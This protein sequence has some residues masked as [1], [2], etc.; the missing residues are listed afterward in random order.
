[1]KTVELEKFEQKTTNI[2]FIQMLSIFFLLFSFALFLCKYFFLSFFSKY[3]SLKKCQYEIFIPNST[4]YA[5]TT[6][7]AV[8]DFHS[9]QFT[10]HRINFLY[11]NYWNYNPY[12]KSNIFKIRVICSNDFTPSFA[13]LSSQIKIQ[14]IPV[15]CFDS[16]HDLSCRV[17]EG[18]KSFLNDS[19]NKKIGWLF[20]ATD[21][22]FIDF[23]NLF[24]YI[25][26]LNKNY[27]SM[28]DLVVRAHANFEMKSNYYIHGGPGY[29]MSREYV[30]YHFVSNLTLNR[31]KA[32][33]KYKQDDT[34]ESIIVRKM[35]KRYRQWD[36][37]YIDGF[38]CRNCHLTNVQSGN[39]PKCPPDKRIGN[40]KKM[41]SFHM[42]GL[43][44]QQLLFLN[45]LDK[46]H[47]HNKINISLIDNVRFY[48]DDNSQ[49]LMLCRSKFVKTENYNTD[50]NKKIQISQLKNPLIDIKSLKRESDYSYLFEK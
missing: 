17:D 40:L 4:K 34:A 41:I 12:L 32:Y 45:L 46:I 36:E 11:K 49:S 26:M 9:S 30:K 14:L 42:F 38:K 48:N 39:L 28:K 27:D 13:N 15:K 19:D 5:L 35:F 24:S 10:F 20:R 29:L 21:D 7:L 47:Q 44:D 37:F 2:P 25:T 33:S 16:I 43:K 50:C 3:L 18:Y 22:S 1:M 8:I 23:E 31:L 6:P